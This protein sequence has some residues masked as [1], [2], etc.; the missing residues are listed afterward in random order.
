M[1]GQRQ[2]VKGCGTMSSKHDMT[3]HNN[4]KLPEAVITYITHILEKEEAHKAPLH[5]LTG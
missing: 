2:G 1:L 4:H 3:W 5:I